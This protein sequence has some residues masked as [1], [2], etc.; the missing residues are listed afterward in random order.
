M[1]EEDQLSNKLRLLDKIKN[2]QRN[3]LDEII[4]A[5][6]YLDVLKQKREIQKQDAKGLK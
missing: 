3:A 5:F 6:M 2:Q 1:L 4:N